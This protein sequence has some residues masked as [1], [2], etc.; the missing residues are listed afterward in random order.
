MLAATNKNLRTAIQEGRFRSDLFFRLNVIPIAVPPLRER[1]S[2]I[3]LL[4]KYFLKW[5]GQ[6]HG[7]AKRFSKK[8]LELMQNYRWPGN[9]RELRNAM[10]R[11]AIMIDHDEIS[12]DDLKR[13]LPD[14]QAIADGK[15]GFALLDGKSLR[16][17]MADFEKHILAEAYRHSKGNVSR[18]ARLLKTDRANLHRKLS[19][20]GIR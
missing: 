9:V 11:A 17:K 1:G 12:A 8:A 3:E 5:A 20:Y 7:V 2:D 15:D 14:L 13:I 10:E 18:M 19:R 4:A 6:Q 16:E